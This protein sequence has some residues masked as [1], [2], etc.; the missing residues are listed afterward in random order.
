MNR[1]YKK[2]VSIIYALLDHLQDTEPREH[3]RSNN[4]VA[5]IDAEERLKWAKLIEKDKEAA[6]KNGLEQLKALSKEI[7]DTQQINGLA[8][9]WKEEMRKGYLSNTE[10]QWLLSI[11]RVWGLERNLLREVDEALSL[12]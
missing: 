8:G 10:M 9:I 12:E 6:Q 5:E 11:A 7:S 3:P 2:A 4:M 1:S